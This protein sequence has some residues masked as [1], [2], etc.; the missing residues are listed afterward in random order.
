MSNTKKHQ[1]PIQ[2]SED[3][4]W[5]LAPEEL[6]NHIKA[7]FDELR[8]HALAA[9]DI[10]N[11][12]MGVVTMIIMGIVTAIC[13]LAL[14]GSALWAFFLAIAS[15]LEVKPLLAFA[16]RETYIKAIKTDV[17]SWKLKDID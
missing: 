5:S 2:Y 7:H 12:R 1:L 4:G 10:S 17:P 8:Q 16:E 3:G 6:D 15:L 11:K 14:T 13:V 9:R